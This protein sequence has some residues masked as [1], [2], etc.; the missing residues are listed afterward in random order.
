MEVS[1][2][3][4]A[5]AAL[6]PRKA[7]GT[8]WIRDWVGPLAVL[9]AVSKRKIPSPCRQSNSNPDHPARCLVAIPT[10]L[11]L[12]CLDKLLKRT[13]SKLQFQLEVHIYINFRYYIVN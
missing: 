2:Q 7:T 8:H 12:F 5:L 10:K 9:D 3:L 6:P 1:D 4:N 13:T 11:S